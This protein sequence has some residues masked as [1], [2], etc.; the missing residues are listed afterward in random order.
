MLIGSGNFLARLLYG[1][2]I[3]CLI[4][5]SFP[6]LYGINVRPVAPFGSVSRKPY[7]DPALIK[8][9][10]PDELLHEVL[11]YKTRKLRFYIWWGKKM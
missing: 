6:D 1:V 10:L 7:V 4:G 2:F 9:C 8:R 5:V 11:Q 3:W